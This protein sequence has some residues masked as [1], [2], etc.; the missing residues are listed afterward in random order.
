MLRIC[1]E[2]L[3]LILLYDIAA[4]HEQHARCNLAGKAHLVGNN[5]HGHAV[6]G[7]LLHDFKHLTDHFR[8]KRRGRLVEQ[9]HIRIHCQR[10]R[11]GDTLLL[12]AGKLRR[13]AVRLVRQT[14]TRKQLERTLVR[15]FIG[16]DLE[17]DRCQLDILAHGQVREQVELLEHHAHTAA[18][19]IDVRV[20]GGNVLSLEDN[21]AAGRLLEQV[22]AA[23]KGR[24]ARAGRADDYDLLAL[25]DMLVDTLEHLMVAKGFVQVFNVDHFR[26]AS[27][28]KCRA[29]WSG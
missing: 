20:L 14:D 25:L 2:L 4:V 6:V 24:L 18:H 21:L 29:A 22:Q 27:S 9:H 5:D 10:T 15:L 16:H 11:D 8:V 3:R 7:Q 19:Q 12:T 28:Q 13:I 1:E 26:A 23:Q 17:L